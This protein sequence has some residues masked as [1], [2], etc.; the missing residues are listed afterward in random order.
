MALLL[1]QSPYMKTQGRTELAQGP[2]EKGHSGTVTRMGEVEH[3][4]RRLAGTH[5]SN[6]QK[7][8]KQTPDLPAPK[9]GPA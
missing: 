6:M 9:L 5:S 3:R 2:K 1:P 8:H 7:P 4:K